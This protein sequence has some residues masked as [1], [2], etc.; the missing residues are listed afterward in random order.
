[1]MSLGFQITNM[2]VI[3]F[4]FIS[5]FLNVFEYDYFSAG[6]FIAGLLSLLLLPIVFHSLQLKRNEIKG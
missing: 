6:F 4:W 3:G 2:F 5:G 1:M